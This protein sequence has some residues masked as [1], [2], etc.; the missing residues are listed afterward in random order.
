[1]AS[2]HGSVSTSKNEG[3]EASH[4]RSTRPGVTGGTCRSVNEVYNALGIWLMLICP[5]QVA[6][7]EH[8][9]GQLINLDIETLGSKGHGSAASARSL[10]IFR[11]SA[12]LRNI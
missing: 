8:V 12:V 10:H 5:R 9:G 1:M 3:K 4:G 7:R 2:F 6:H 11:Q